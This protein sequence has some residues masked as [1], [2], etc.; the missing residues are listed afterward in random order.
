MHIDGAGALLAATSAEGKAP[1]ASTT[2]LTILPALMAG[3]PI[4]ATKSNEG[5]T[6]MR[7]PFKRYA[8]IR[9]ARFLLSLFMFI[10]LCWYFYTGFGGPSELVA[11]LVPVAVAV[12]ILCMHENGFIYK[13]LPP[14]ANNTLVVIYLGICLFA[15]YHFVT[16]YEEIAIWRQGS[17]TRTD[18]IMGLLVFLLVMELSRASTPICSG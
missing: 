12:Q 7:E 16:Q 2:A 5:T 6:D 8:T 11:A 3:L 9:N 14:V 17:Y 1:A 18:F 10:W 15:F 13:K 4:I